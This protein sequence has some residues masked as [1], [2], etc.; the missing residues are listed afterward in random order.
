MSLHSLLQ[1]QGMGSV[2][3]LYHASTGWRPRLSPEVLHCSPATR[4]VET[5]MSLCIQQ[6][7]G[8][9]EARVNTT[10][11]CFTAAL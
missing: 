2:T 6:E 7:M 5:V 9:T 3:K 11:S 1:R 4:A 10:L 8:P